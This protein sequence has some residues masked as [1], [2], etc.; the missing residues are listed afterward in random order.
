MRLEIKGFIILDFL[1]EDGG[2]KAA[3]ATRELTRA[4]QEGKITIS[5]ENETVIA[6]GFEDVPRTWMQLFEGGN[7]GKL[8]TKVTPSSG[9][10]EGEG[11]SP[12]L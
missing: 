12:C 6:N 2:R 11:P 7:T 4:V 1:R 5:D 10:G 9:Y 3:E 8:I